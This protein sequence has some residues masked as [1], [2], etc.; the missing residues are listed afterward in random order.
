MMIL[1]DKT[2]SNQHAC[3]NASIGHSRKKVK[4]ETSASHSG[5]RTSSF[6]F[7]ENLDNIVASVQVEHQDV[8]THIYPTSSQHL[9]G[10]EIHLSTNSIGSDSEEARRRYGLAIPWQKG[11]D[12]VLHRGRNS[13]IKG[14]EVYQKGRF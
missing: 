5:S 1:P 9:V 10:Y 13:L 8:Q 14:G 12:D 2:K 11:G 7:D 4:T 6:S 3:F